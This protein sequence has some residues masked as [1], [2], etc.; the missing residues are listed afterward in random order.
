[1]IR[2]PK[3][4]RV[5]KPKRPMSISFN[6]KTI[7]TGAQGLIRHTAKKRVNELVKAN[8]NTLQVRITHF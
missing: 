1:M 7:G 8:R 6:R 2:L 4:Y 5:D 3:E